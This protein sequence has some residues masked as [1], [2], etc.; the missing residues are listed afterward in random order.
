MG[1][2]R[3]MGCYISIITILGRKLMPGQRAI[4]PKPKPSTSCFEKLRA[5]LDAQLNIRCSNLTPAELRDFLTQ[6]DSSEEKF[7]RMENL[8]PRLNMTNVRK[9]LELAEIR[10]YY[11]DTLQILAFLEAVQEP[12]ESPHELTER[13]ASLQTPKINI[14]PEAQIRRIVFRYLKKELRPD[15]LG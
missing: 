5:E 14:D 11:H 10:K 1:I 8:F 7:A 3:S 13:L 15:G 6:G 12:E 4:E 2:V 9:L